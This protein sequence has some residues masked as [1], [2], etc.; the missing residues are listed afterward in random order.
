VRPFSRSPQTLLS[1]TDRPR[2]ST[3]EGRGSSRNKTTL[4]A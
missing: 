1:E 4:R 3:I 2:P